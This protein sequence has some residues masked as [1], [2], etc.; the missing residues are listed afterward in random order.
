MGVAAGS[1]DVVVMSS[2]GLTVRTNALVAVT[3]FVSVTWMVKFE[4]AAVAGWPVI[5]PVAEFNKSG[6]GK[7]PTVTAHV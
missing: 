7:A 1:G 4:V 6:L 5:A 2:A 3:W